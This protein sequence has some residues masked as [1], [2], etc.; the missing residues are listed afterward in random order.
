MRVVHESNVTA[1]PLTEPAD[2]RGSGVWTLAGNAPIIA[3]PGGPA[4]VLVPTEQ[5]RLLA[6]DLP[7]QGRARRLEALPFAI[8]DRIAEPLESV[9]IAL[10]V[11]LAPKRHLVGV[12]R[13]DV[14]A[15]WVERAEAEG[16]GG[17]RFVPDALAL[18]LPTEGGWAVDLD[19]WR[20]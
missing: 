6:V 4:T 14:M 9:H 17:A 5:V 18:P 20:A 12:V 8:E 2:S 11:E 1:M 19:S 16:L 3:E 15:D 7:V 10:G 13:H